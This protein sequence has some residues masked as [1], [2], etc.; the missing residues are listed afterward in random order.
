MLH[1]SGANSVSY[2][3]SRAWAWPAQE[4]RAPE[5]EAGRA[6]GGAARLYRGEEIVWA[7]KTMW[8]VDERFEKK[9]MD[10][11]AALGFSVGSTRGVVRVEKY[12]QVGHRLSVKTVSIRKAM[13]W[14]SL[15]P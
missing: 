9:Q 10:S 2:E 5:G 8:N 3:P 7:E 14:R 6:R 13:K 1:D 4:R 15:R 12:G 11:L